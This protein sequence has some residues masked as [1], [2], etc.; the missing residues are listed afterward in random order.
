MSNDN[1]TLADVQPGGRVRLGDGLPPLPI[2]QRFTTL[3]GETYAYSA[4]QMQDYARA[5]LSAQP[6]PGGQGDVRSQ[7]EA[8][9]CEKFKT[10]WQTGAPTRD[11]HNGVY[12]DNYGPAEQQERWELW[13]AAL[14]ACHPVRIYGCC[15]Q[16]EG[17]LHT[18]ECPNMRHLAVR[19][20]SKQPDSVALGEATE[21]C[22]EKGD[23]QPVGEPD[24]FLVQAV[25]DGET[26]EHRWYVPRW[27]D[28]D[29]SA[30]EG[31]VYEIRGRKHPELG[32]YCVKPFYAAPAQAVD[33]DAIRGAVCGIALVFDGDLPYIKGIAEALALIDSQ[34]VGNG[35]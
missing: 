11:M 21:F 23:R 25:K 9:H 8:W 12:A 18:S 14:A 13:Q 3:H 6:S 28:P 1:K 34:A 20:P 7:F 5:A 15:A 22:I 31:A 26:W 16:P 2:R 10:R 17:E 30:L 35:N 32:I 24:A 33:L 4:E 27:G 29:P 19:Q